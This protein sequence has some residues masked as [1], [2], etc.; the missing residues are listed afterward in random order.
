VR[1]VPMMNKTELEKD[2]KRLRRLVYDKRREFWPDRDP[3][4]FEMVDPILAA[5]AL[6]LSVELHERFSLTISG[7]TYEAAGALDR[8]SKSVVVATRFGEGT[9]RFTLAHELGHWLRHR[10]Q[11]HFRDVQPIGG[12]ERRVSDPRER[13]ADHFAALYLLPAHFVQKLFRE[14]FQTGDK[15]FVFNEMTIDLLGRE[16]REELLYPEEGSRIR[17]RA[18]ASAQSLTAV[19]SICPFMQCWG[20]RLRPWLSGWK[21]SKWSDPGPKSGL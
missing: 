21:N 14:F 5:R 9:T 10:D 3:H 2:A 20:F 18:L 17:E 12:L 6:G 13:E 4:P 16:D 19:I 1:Q 15:P 11:V 8:E 7:R